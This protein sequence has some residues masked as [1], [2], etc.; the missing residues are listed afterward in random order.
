MDKLQEMRFK[1]SMLGLEIGDVI[2]CERDGE[3]LHSV[4]LKRRD[5]RGRALLTLSCFSPLLTLQEHP[6]EVSWDTQLGLLSD[7][8]GRIMLFSEEWENTD[9][10]GAKLLLVQASAKNQSIERALAIL[11]AMKDPQKDFEENAREILEILGQ[12][13]SEESVKL[14]TF[15]LVCASRE[16]WN[17]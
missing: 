8:G 16:V 11:I 6:K 7:T 4:V 1:V 14:L 10:E 17:L 5:E 15:A 3:K 2:T 9:K 13:S 12:A